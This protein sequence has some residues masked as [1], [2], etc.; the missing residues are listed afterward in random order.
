MRTFLPP[1]AIFELDAELRRRIDD[2]ALALF[3]QP[4]KVM[5]NKRE[6]RF[7]SK[8]ALCI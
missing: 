4:N 1:A 3:G 5:T 8:G 2:L 6:L 7:G